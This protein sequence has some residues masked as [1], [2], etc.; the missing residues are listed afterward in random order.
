MCPFWLPN[1]AVEKPIYTI[2]ILQAFNL[3][4]VSKIRGLAQVQEASPNT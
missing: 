3:S 4:L 2:G 1:V